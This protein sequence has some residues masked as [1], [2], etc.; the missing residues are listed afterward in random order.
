[1]N[2]PMTKNLNPFSRSQLKIAAPL[3]L[4]STNY[5]GWSQSYEL[6]YRASRGAANAGLLAKQF[7]VGTPLVVQGKHVVV[8]SATLTLTNG[9]ID[10][11]T[12]RVEAVDFAAVLAQ[13]TAQS[14]P[15]IA[16]ANKPGHLAPVVPFTFGGTK[17]RILQ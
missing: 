12:I 4:V 17:R 7:K 8:R 10:E 13:A 6:E 3:S 2:H 15:R 9:T 16:A 11:V 1:V 14:T 5:V